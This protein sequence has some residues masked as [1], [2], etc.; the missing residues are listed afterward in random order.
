METTTKIIEA[1]I[2]Y[3]NGW[4]TIPNINCSRHE[5]IAL[6]AIDPINFGRYHIESAVSAEAS[7]S[8][9]TVNAKGNKRRM[10]IAYFAE[11]KFDAKSI[12]HELKRYGFRK[13]NYTKVIVCWG[14]EDDARRDASLRQIKLW[15][16]HEIFKK[17]TASLQKESGFISDETL[18]A[19]QLS[20]LYMKQ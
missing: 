18:Q 1:Y 12:L 16:F 3:M 6:L 17:M 14:W 5:K 4:A 9:L 2:R 13:G 10:T 19:L 11:K 20:L 8:K 15:D 7:N